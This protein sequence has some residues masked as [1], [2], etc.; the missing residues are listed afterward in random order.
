MDDLNSER[1]AR[2]TVTAQSLGPGIEHVVIPPSRRLW[3]GAPPVFT[4]TVVEQAPSVWRS[5][6]RELATPVGAVRVKAPGDHFRTLDASQPSGNNML[7]LAPK[8]VEQLGSPGIERAFGAVQIEDAL[9]S[10]AIVWAPESD[11]ITSSIVELL[12]RLM[13]VTLLKGPPSRGVRADVVQ[14]RRTID[15]HF[16]QALSLEGLAAEI[17]VHPGTLVRLFRSEF[18]IPPLAYLIERRVEAAQHLLCNGRSIAEVAVE[19]GFCDQSHL[20]RHFKRRTGLTPARFAQEEAQR[21]SQ[22]TFGR[23]ALEHARSRRS[24]A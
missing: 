24:S 19:V 16:D 14:V 9:L 15:R 11:E 17:D 3:S 7:R 13:T 18:G 22:R 2:R 10:Q 8:V 4:L 6:G 1:C 21:A 5:R 12:A 20:T 23:R